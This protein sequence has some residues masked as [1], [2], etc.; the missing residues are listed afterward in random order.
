MYNSLPLLLFYLLVL[1]LKD[2][3]TLWCHCCQKD[4]AL[5][6]YVGEEHRRTLLIILGDVCKEGILRW[7]KIKLNFCYIT[8]HPMSPTTFS[9]CCNHCNPTKS[10]NLSSHFNNTYCIMYTIITCTYV[11]CK[12]INP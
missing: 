1:T 3:L 2:N 5:K 9:G 8:R 4:D 11:Y 7:A 6:P 12:N 10:L